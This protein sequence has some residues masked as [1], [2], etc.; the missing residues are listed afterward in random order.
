MPVFPPDQTHTGEMLLRYEDIAQDGRAGF[1]AGPGEAARPRCY[2][3]AAY[4]A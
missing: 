3:R 4:R 1:I 2:V